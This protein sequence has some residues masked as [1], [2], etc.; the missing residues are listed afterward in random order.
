M[1]AVEMIRPLNTCFCMSLIAALA[2]SDSVTSTADAADAPIKVLFLGDNGRHRPADRFKR[3]EP[4]LRNRGIEAQYTEN[5]HDLNVEKLKQ[6]SALMVYANIDNIEPREAKAL[7]EYVEAG[8]GFVPLH[9]ASYCF[10]NAPEVVALIGGQFKSHGTGT[11]RT[12]QADVEHPILKG[13]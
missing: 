8:G 10:R 1:R 13:F 5:I 3:I 4:V 11:F 12:V 7:I 2:L 9:C 6:Y